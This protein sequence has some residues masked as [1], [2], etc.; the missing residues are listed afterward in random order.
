MLNKIALYVLRNKTIINWSYVIRSRNKRII[1]LIFVCA[2]STV[3]MDIELENIV[4]I[5]AYPNKMFSFQAIITIPPDNK[6]IS[7]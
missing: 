5:L 2:K 4:R 3:S 6:N 1:Y 7:L